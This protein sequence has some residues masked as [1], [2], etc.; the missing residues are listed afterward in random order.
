[1]DVDFLE[2][3][4][5]GEVQERDRFALSQVRESAL[6]FLDLSL[7]FGRGLSVDDEAVFVVAHVDVD[8][9]LLF[10]VGLTL[11]ITFFLNLFLEFI[12]GALE[13]F[14]DL[15]QLIVLPPQSLQFLLQI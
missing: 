15:S 8:A 12:V 7:Q 3:S 10:G 9:E 13:L 2:L 1:L 11:D 4:L 6:Q 14:I 5:F